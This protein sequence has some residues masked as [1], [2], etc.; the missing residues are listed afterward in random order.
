MGMRLGQGTHLGR[1]TFRRRSS[2]VCAAL[3]VFCAANSVLR[4]L[5]PIRVSAWSP[6]TIMRWPYCSS[7]R[8]GAMR[9]R[10]D[11]DVCG[12]MCLTGS[13]R[14]AGGQSLLVSPFSTLDTLFRLITHALLP[15]DHRS[16]HPSPKPNALTSVS[17]ATSARRR[18]RRQRVVAA[19]V[20][21]IR[22]SVPGRRGR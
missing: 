9:N 8:Q 20:A 15:M 2:L 11:V 22:P 14:R 12:C 13:K 4:F 6:G 19:Y 7:A 5:P 21:I 17:G 18:V 3:A 16:H 1:W 10:S